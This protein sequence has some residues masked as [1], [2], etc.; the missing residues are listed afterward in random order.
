M[1]RFRRYLI[2]DKDR[3]KPCLNIGGPTNVRVIDI[4]DSLPGLTDSQRKQIREEASSGA[5][6]LQS[7]EPQP[8]T[9]RPSSKHSD[10]RHPHIPTNT[11]G[12]LSYNTETISHHSFTG[13]SPEEHVVAPLNTAPK[14]LSSNVSASRRRRRQDYSPTATRMK[15]TWSSDRPYSSG[16]SSEYDISR[17]P[18]ANEMG[19]ELKKLRTESP[20]ALDVDKGGH[21]QDSAHGAKEEESMVT[22]HAAVRRPDDH[23]HVEHD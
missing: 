2:C 11:L 15:S 20:H 12:S 22:G 5:L 6:R 8:L 10:T 17:S 14:D 7:M 19:I 21:V 9:S 16:S 4:S 1:V 3:P 23:V 13:V 18:H